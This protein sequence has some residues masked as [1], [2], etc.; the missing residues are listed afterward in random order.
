MT[1]AEVAR[2]KR[3]KDKNIEYVKAYRKKHYANMTEEQKTKRD[4]SQKKSY[5]RIR[6]GITPEF[7]EGML[8]GQDYRCAI[9]GKELDLSRGTRFTCLD[10]DHNTGKIRQILCHNCNKGLGHFFE[11]EEIML[12]AIEYLRK[13]RVS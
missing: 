9:C 6:Y 4:K 8:Q 12:S 2:S 1:A 11:S 3:W 7:Y 13:W 5:L 10:H